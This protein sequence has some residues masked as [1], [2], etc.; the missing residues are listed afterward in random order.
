MS[1]SRSSRPKARR[2]SSN[3]ACSC[4][5]PAE[6]RPASTAGHFGRRGK[7]AVEAAEAFEQDARQID[8]A[9]SGHPDAQ[10]DAASSSASEE[11]PRP[12]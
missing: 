10:E 1:R 8:G 2:T 6:P 5:R 11:R 4:V 9:H 12:A 3:T 7:Q